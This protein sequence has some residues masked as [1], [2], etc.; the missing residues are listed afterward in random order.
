M[1]LLNF[2]LFYVFTRIYYILDTR[3]PPQDSLGRPPNIGRLTNKSHYWL[4][5][6]TR[7]AGGFHRSHFGNKSNGRQHLEKRPAKQQPVG[8]FLWGEASLGSAIYSLSR[9]AGD[10]APSL[11]SFSMN[12]PLG[13][14]RRRLGAFLSADRPPV[15]I[16]GRMF[17]N[18]AP[19]VLVHLEKGRE[20]GWPVCQKAKD[21]NKAHFYT[22][23]LKL[24][25]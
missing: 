17:W 14:W 15:L 22:D 2:V 20:Q 3:F 18:V 9:V 23:H 7:G 21:F 11:T 1:F 12:L 24:W 10:E 13:L 19:H 6:S 5:P 4:F 8:R 25:I 16:D